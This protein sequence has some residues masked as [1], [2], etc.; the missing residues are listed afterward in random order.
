MCNDEVLYK[1]LIFYL[2][3]FAF[4][5][6]KHKDFSHVQIKNI[7]TDCGMIS[8]IFQKNVDRKKR[9]HILKIVKGK[10][11]VSEMMRRLFCC[12]AYQ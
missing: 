1:H 12:H 8:E 4:N 11:A 6:R 5:S 3:L 9:G 7:N 2:F 10:G